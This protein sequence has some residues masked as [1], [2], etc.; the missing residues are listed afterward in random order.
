MEILKTLLEADPS[1][2]RLT[3]YDET[4][5]GRTDLSAI[6]LDNW[7]SK[8][9]NMLHDEFDLVAGDQV[10][11]D[12]PLIWQAAC[13]ILG[14]ERAGVTVNDEDPLVVFTTAANLSTWEEK[15]PDAYLAVLTD[16]P[17]GRGVTECGDDIPPGVIDFGPEVRFHPDAYLGAGPTSEK[18]P[19][20]GDASAEDLRQLAS[21]FSSQLELVPK[22]RIV[23]H[24]WLDSESNQVN[25]SLWARNVLSAWL[26]GGAAV[27]VRGGDAA[28][29][30][31]IAGSE[32][33]RVV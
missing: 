5:G 3:C 10:W 30:E 15:L 14:C 21:D 2:P 33:A 19:V 26:S 23:S 12:L 28:R 1:A 13:I 17:F 18:T 4:T 25:A 22:S 20:I 8:I 24:G 6:T 11:I 27:V 9:A 31:A 7:A 29:L 32:R 16:D